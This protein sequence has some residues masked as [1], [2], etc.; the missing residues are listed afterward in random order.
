MRSVAL[1]CSCMCLRMDQKLVQ[2]RQAEREENHEL[3]FKSLF[4][5][6]NNITI[7]SMTNNVIHIA[8]RYDIFQMCHFN[9]KHKKAKLID[10]AEEKL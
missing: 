7:L 10:S 4:H 6:L 5:T 3:F 9:I 1:P 8:H 2:A